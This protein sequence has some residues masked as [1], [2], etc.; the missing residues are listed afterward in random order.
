MPYGVGFL[1]YVLI[2]IAYRT[3]QDRDRRLVA[4]R[5]IGE[6]P[7]RYGVRRLPCGKAYGLMAKAAKGWSPTLTCRD[8]NRWQT[9]R[10]APRPRLASHLSPRH[11]ER[12]GAADR[13]CEDPRGYYP[14]PRPR[15]RRAASPRRDLPRERPGG[16]NCRTPSSD[17]VTRP[18]RGLGRSCSP[19]GI[20]PRT[21]PPRT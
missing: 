12:H 14:R 16:N 5:A 13:H 2:A 9:E 21:I 18:D 4:G 17:T 6:V 1:T 19:S 8:R 10:I 11:T 7:E 20:P 3:R 15:G